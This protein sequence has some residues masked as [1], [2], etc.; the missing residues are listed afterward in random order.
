MFSRRSF[1]TEVRVQSKANLCEVFGRQK[2]PCTGL[3]PIALAFPV[4]NV[5]TVLH[6]ALHLYAAL[7]GQM[8][9]DW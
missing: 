6:A 7:Q 2:G 1:T 4:S 3:P 9:V 8:W 5:P